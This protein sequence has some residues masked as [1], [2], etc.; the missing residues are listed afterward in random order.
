MPDHIRDLTENDDIFVVW[1][2]S[3]NQIVTDY[4][5]LKKSNWP[6]WSMASAINAR[7]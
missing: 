5:L 6:G 3:Q 4:D 2:I 1:D 7:Y